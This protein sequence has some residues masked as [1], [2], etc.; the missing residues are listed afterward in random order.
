MLE[1]AQAVLRLT[2]SKSQLKF[3]PLPQ[4]D[5]KQRCPDITRAKKMLGWSPRVSLESGLVED[6]RVLPGR[7]SGKTTGS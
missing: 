2:G 6:D 5:P 3:M 4:D 7:C 1:L